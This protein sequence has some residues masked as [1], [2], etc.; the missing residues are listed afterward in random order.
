MKLPNSFHIVKSLWFCHLIMVQ[1][2]ELGIIIS[3][4]KLGN[5]WRD[6]EIIRPGGSRA[7]LEAMTPHFMLNSVLLLTT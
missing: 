4:Y 3:F 1:L 6:N 7:I 2:Y 5:R